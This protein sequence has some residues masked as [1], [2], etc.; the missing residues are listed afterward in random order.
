[1]TMTLTQALAESR[2]S[3]HDPHEVDAVILAHY[4]RVE[5]DTL[6]RNTRKWLIIGTAIFSLV[7]VGL[8]IA[9]SQE[10]KGMTLTQQQTLTEHPQYN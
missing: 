4:A 2:M 1:M 6:N 10:E 7:F 3:K 5:L 9:K 8:L